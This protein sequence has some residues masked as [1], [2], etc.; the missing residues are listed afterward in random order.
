M[1]GGR[2]D[3]RTAEIHFQIPSVDLLRKEEGLRPILLMLPL[4]R[5]KA[6][7]A[8]IPHVSFSNDEN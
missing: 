5:V 3:G 1:T 7:W 8:K 6:Q 2:T 4:S